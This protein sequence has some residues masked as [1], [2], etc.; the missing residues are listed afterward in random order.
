[1]RYFVVFL[2][3]LGT[4]GAQAD[5]AETLKLQDKKDRL[6]FR[7]ELLLLNKPIDSLSKAELLE[8][9]ETLLAIAHLDS[10]IIESQKE[11][12]DR[13]NMVASTEHR[14]YGSVVAFSFFTFIVVLLSLYFLYLMNAKLNKA[15]G[16]NVSYLSSLKEFIIGTLGFFGPSKEGNK[17]STVSNLI[18]IIGLLFMLA[19]FTA[20]LF[21]LI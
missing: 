2:L 13:V 15:T 19:S 16:G 20:Y 10:A 6:K 5:I 3:L 14:S 8:Y 17:S 18:I 12:I 11:T 4:V 1:M 21:R 7:N 9:N